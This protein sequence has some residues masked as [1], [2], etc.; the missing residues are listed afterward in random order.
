MRL[1]F[2]GVKN[3]FDYFQIG[4][5]ESFVRRIS[6][7][8][9]HC[10]TTVD[11][12]LYGANEEKTFRPYQGLTLKYFKLFKDALKTLNKNYDHIITIYLLPKHRANFATFR[13]NHTD[14]SIYHFIYFGWPDSIIKRKLY[15]A[16]AKLFPYNGKLFCISPRQYKYASQWA[17]NAVYILPPVP[18]DYFLE[19]EEKPTNNKIK[20][21]FLGRIDPGKGIKDVIRLFDALKNNDRYEFNIYGIHIPEDKESLEIHQCLKKQRQIQYHEV[22][23]QHY[24]PEVD[25]F[26]KNVLKK[27]DIF[28][29]P[30]LKLSSTID[31]PLLLLEAMASLCPVITKPFGN[32]PD[33]YGTSK[34]LIPEK[35]NFPEMT[36]LLNAISTDDIQ[37]ERARI[38]EQNRKLNFNVN[39]IAHQ[40]INSLN[41]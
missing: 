39:Q 1:A 41:G 15:F 26:V 12:I 2:L 25:E 31:T 32:I 11:Y 16:E 10:N 36:K 27:T 5:V 23:R 30:Y 14:K 40:F 18:D 21:T 19:P 33:I 35:N 13:K 8:L 24:S 38:Y 6:A 3:S 28:V 37:K 9:I 4:G 7:Q 17:R 29:Q 34:F 20:I 22:D